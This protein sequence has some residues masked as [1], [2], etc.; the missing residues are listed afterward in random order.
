EAALRTEIALIAEQ[1]VEEAE[2]ARVRT[3]TLASETY[4]RD[5]LM[6][7]AMEIGFL[8]AA[9]LSWRDEQALLDGVR[10]VTAEDVQDVARRYFHDE[11]LTRAILRPQ[12]LE[13][14]NG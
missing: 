13:D 14:N 3:Q 11:S 2:L 12:S 7:Q 8:E 9:G 4:K 6:G 5:S 1:G 10:A